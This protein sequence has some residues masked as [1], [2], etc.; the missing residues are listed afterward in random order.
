MHKT[1]DLYVDMYKGGSDMEK[2]EIQLREICHARSGDKADNVNVGLIANDKKFY[3]TLL[4]QVTEARVK[5]HFQGIVEG[6]V[7]RYEMENI[8]AL[9][10]VMTHALGGG[11]ARTLFVDNIGKCYGANLL[12]MKI[13]IDSALLDA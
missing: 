8:K 6:N 11:A 13:L 3:P 9:N 5:E 1:D 4:E 10:F 12:R 2:V 7:K